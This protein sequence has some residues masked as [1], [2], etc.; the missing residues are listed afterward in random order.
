LFGKISSDDYEFDPQHDDFVKKASKKYF[1]RYKSQLKISQ[2]LLLSDGIIDE[3]SAQKYL[4]RQLNKTFVVV[5]GC[6][7]FQ[8]KQQ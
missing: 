1:F 2:K 3:K 6:P 5:R 4:G 8:N 7:T